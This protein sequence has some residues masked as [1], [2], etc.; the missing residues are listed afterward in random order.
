M[1]RRYKIKDVNITK[2]K[3]YLKGKP[4]KDE[5]NTRQRTSSTR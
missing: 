2:L 5:R 1:K 4:N 3:T